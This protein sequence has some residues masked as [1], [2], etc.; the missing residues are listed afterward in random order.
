[1]PRSGPRGWP[2]AELRH[3]GVRG[4]Q[5][6]LAAATC[7]VSKGKSMS[8]LT[9]CWKP[10]AAHPARPVLAISAHKVADESQV[11]QLTLGYLGTWAIQ[12]KEKCEQGKEN[13]TSGS[14]GGQADPIDPATKAQLLLGLST[15]GLR[16]RLCG[17]AVASRGGR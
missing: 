3:L 13:C 16:A 12:G 8:Q 10:C 2:S 6:G 14:S 17:P 5:L 15:P 9:V 4:A 7:D 11:P 1:M